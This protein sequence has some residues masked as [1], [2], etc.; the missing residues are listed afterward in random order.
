MVRPKLP[1]TDRFAAIER[2]HPHHP[3]S[4]TL[5]APSAEIFGNA[6]ESPQKKSTPIAPLS[7]YGGSK[8]LG[9]FLIGSYRARGLHA[10]SVIL[11]NHESPLRPDG[12]FTR[13]ISRGVARIAR[14][15]DDALTLG[16]LDVHWDWG[17]GPDYPEFGKDRD[18]D[19][20]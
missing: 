7:P 3:K 9:H 11:C 5:A 19:R 10:S 1:S 17:R 14:S 4:A 2:T 8:V 6:A 13:R 16:T 12:F 18:C 15:L 20:G